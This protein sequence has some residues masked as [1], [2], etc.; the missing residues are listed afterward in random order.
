MRARIEQEL[1][2]LR[3]HYGAVDHAEAAGDDWFRLPC[4]RLSQGWRIG[5][6]EVAEVP[7]AFLVTAA[8]PGTAPYG[9]L[10]PANMNFKGAAPANTGSPPKTPPFAGDWMHFSWSVENWMATNDVCKGSNLLAWCRGF[11]ERFKEGT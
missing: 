10:A 1:A 3:Q 11:A 8:H 6:R 2:L 4:Y 9:F 5:E 7:I